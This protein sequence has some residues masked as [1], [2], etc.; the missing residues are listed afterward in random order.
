MHSPFKQAE[1]N[2]YVQKQPEQPTTQTN[3]RLLQLITPLLHNLQQAGHAIPAELVNI[4]TTEQQNDTQQA[5]LQQVQQDIADLQQQLQTAE[6]QAQILTNNYQQ[7]YQQISTHHGI[8]TQQLTF[9]QEKLAMIQQQQLLTQQQQG[10]TAQPL[11][12]PTPATPHQSA[13]QTPLQDTTMRTPK[14]DKNKTPT[15]HI[16]TDSDDNNNTRTRRQRSADNVQLQTPTSKFPKPLQVG[17]LAGVAPK[18]H[19][20]KSVATAPFRQARSLPPD[21]NALLLTPP[22]PQFTQQDQ[23]ASTTPPLTQQTTSTQPYQDD[24]PPE[25]KIPP[26]DEDP[27]STDLDITGVEDNDQ[28]ATNQQTIQTG[29]NS[30]DNQPDFNLFG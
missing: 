26:Y 21:R 4:I 25:D 16:A 24:P 12:Y 15:H 30:T 29:N 20:V 19:K 14:T 5:A 18:I 17:A 10:A 6:Q 22:L 23:A 9:A 13:P 28:T 7:Q 11:F 8:L 2:Q 3:T 27:A 1:G